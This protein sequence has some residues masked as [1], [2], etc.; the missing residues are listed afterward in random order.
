MSSV[1]LQPVLLEKFFEL[2]L[3]L[4]RFAPFF[5]LPVIADASIHVERFVSVFQPKSTLVWLDIF[6]PVEVGYTFRQRIL[7]KGPGDGMVMNL[8][9]D[10]SH[11]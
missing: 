9:C 6:L 2:A 5:R 3:V 4:A 10:S 8:P 11:R 7:V 1:E